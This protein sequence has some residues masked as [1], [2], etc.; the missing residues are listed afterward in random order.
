MPCKLEDDDYLKLWM[1]FQDRA[2]NIKE[3]MFKTVTWIVGYA[4]ALLGFIFL[5]LTN[6]DT[7]KAAVAR[8]SVVGLAAVAGLVICL[9]SWFALSEAAKHI[10]SNWAQANRCGE[11]VDG[12]AA[13]TH[14]G[15]N[16]QQSTMKI[17]DQL[18]I[19]VAL[20]GIGFLVVL[21]WTLTCGRAA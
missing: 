7:A 20:F 14:S 10:Q 6:Y 12:L 19:I 1:Y 9:Y 3:A 2:D 13:I 17:W 16:K 4:A 15:D 18:R 21:A 5:I 11:K 8:S